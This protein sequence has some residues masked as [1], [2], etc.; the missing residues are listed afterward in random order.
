MIKTTVSVDGMACGMCE[1]HVN[2][3]IRASFPVRKVTSSRARKETVILSDEKLD[4]EAVRR[5]ISGTGYTPG[6]ITEEAVE[7]KGL[8]RFVKR[9]TGMLI[10]PGTASSAPSDTAR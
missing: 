6:R 7:K 10:F 1:A 8:F 3:V 4:H 9:L 5:A 2:D